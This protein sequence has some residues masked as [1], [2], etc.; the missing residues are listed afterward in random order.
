VDLAGL[1][2]VTLSGL[3]AA[4]P[5]LAPPAEA[6]AKWRAHLSDRHGL[7]VGLHLPSGS[8]TGNTCRSALDD[9]VSALRRLPGVALFDLRAGPASIDCPAH[10]GNPSST[11]PSFPRRRFDTGE[12]AAACASMDILIC[13]DGPVA[14]LGGAQGVRTWVLVPSSPS[15]IWSREGTTSPWY[16]S[17]RL[18]REDESVGWAD[19]VPSIVESV[20]SS[21]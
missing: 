11:R 17:V 18:F 15:W 1:L 9:L 14:H 21:D 10:A 16:P 3:T 20:R 8:A 2:Q 13:G 4:E 12:L 7:K 5:Y 6:A 19:A